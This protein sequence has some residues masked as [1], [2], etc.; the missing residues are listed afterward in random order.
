MMTGMFEKK[1]DNHALQWQIRYYQDDDLDGILC[2][3]E[4]AIYSIDD[5]IYSLAQKK[6]WAPLPLAK[7]FWQA[8]LA[9]TKPYVAICNDHIAGF[10]EL[11]HDY[12]DCFYVDPQFQRQGVAK[13]L[14]MAV[15]SVAKSQKLS[16]LTVDASRLAKP[17]FERHG[18][19]VIKENQQIRQ[20]EK[21]INW[22]MQKMLSEQDES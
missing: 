1:D 21:L 20:E 6:A 10:I 5:D 13:S 17:F 22:T 2:V 11:C 18:F 15:E 9:R 19:Y 3:F 4:R 8:R 14:Y 16:L 12:I 7:D